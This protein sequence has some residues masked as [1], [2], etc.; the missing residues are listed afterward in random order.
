MT[1]VENP[2]IT[3]KLEMERQKI[4]RK[5]SERVDQIVQVKERIN[6]FDWKYKK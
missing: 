2:T 1:E 5:I 3:G 4:N 6:Q